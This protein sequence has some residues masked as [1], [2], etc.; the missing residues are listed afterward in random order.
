MVPRPRL[1]NRTLLGLAAAAWMAAACTGIELND[2]GSAEQEL[3]WSGSRAILVNQLGYVPG[4]TKIAVVLSSSGSPLSFEIVSGSGARV[5][6]PANTSVQGLDA[7]SG[8][9]VH[10]ADFSAFAL[11][12]RGYKVRV[13]ATGAE[14]EP[15]DVDADLYGAAQLPKAAVK[16]FYQHRQ[17][18]ALQATYLTDFAS[19]AHAHGGLHWDDDRLKAV[20]SWST[21]TFDV[22]GGWSDAGD[23]GKYADSTGVAAW[24][25]MNLYERFAN[26]GATS[27]SFNIPESSNAIPDLL[28]EVRW[29]LKG[30]RGLLP[31]PG[32]TSAPLTDAHLAAH[33]CHNTN[34]SDFPT[35]ISSENSKYSA[36]N[37]KRLCMKPSTTATYS[38]ARNMAQFARLIS[39]YEP[40]TAAAAWADAKEA[41]RRAKGTPAKLFKAEAS[42]A[43]GGNYPDPDVTDDAYAAAVEMYLTAFARQDDAERLNAYRADV[44]GSP[45]FKFIGTFDWGE[46]AGYDATP[47]TLSLLSARNDLSETDMAAM[48]A[49]VL[50]YANTLESNLSGQ[51]FPSVIHKDAEYVWGSNKLQAY[52]AMLLVFAYELSADTR[53]LK[54]AYRVLDYV[55]GVNALRLSFVTGFGENAERDSHDRWAWQNYPNNA[56]P[57]GWL[58]G[59][60]NSVFVNDSATPTTGPRAKRYAA[61]NT[62]PS[63]WASK[64]NTVDWN[65]GL[66]WVAYALDRYDSVLG[67]GSGPTCTD[68]VKNGSETDVDCG[69]SCGSD[70]VNGK[71]CA[72]SKDCVSQNCVGGVCEAPV[73]GTSPCSGLC[74]PATLITSAS[75]N[76]GNLDT[77]ATCHETSA[78]ISGGNCGNM[79]GRTFKINGTTVNCGGNFVPPA[80][81]NGGYCFQASAGGYSYAYFGTW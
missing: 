69:G 46:Y 32:D 67:S 23:F 58:T 1:A 40:A 68:S 13:L 62:A 6:G 5:F 66:A 16:Y 42:S 37:G 53:Y 36:S 7:A 35:T 63:A 17:G 51:G 76:S 50:A 52:G 48:K 10:H 71:R 64:E 14:S 31:N 75:F 61:G 3:S 34:W 60:P 59:G 8:E 39:A 47:G 11:N 78:P 19:A 25:L 44:T 22:L 81:R 41:Y 56:Y 70:C 49:N 26:K 74:S 30:Q 20:D 80:K 24:L 73:R 12:G 65:A 21:A 57:R 55:F 38:V 54:S 43:G 27:F 18:L 79:A 9:S 72:A 2:T 77:S 4:A 33:K 45:H 28:D 15:F 29:G